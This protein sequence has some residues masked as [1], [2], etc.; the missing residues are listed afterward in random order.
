[1]S[2][3]LM[4]IDEAVRAQQMHALWSR[5]GQWLIGFAVVSVIATIIG[6]IW[7]RHVNAALEDQTGRLLT[8]LQNEAESPDTAKKLGDLAKKTDLPL[9]GVAT[10]YQAQKLEQAKDLKGAQ[11]LYGTMIEQRRLPEIIRNLSR[12]HFARIGLVIGDKPEAL[13]PVLDPVAGNITGKKQTPFHYSALELKGILLVAQGKQDEANTIFTELSSNSDVPG[14]MRA[15]AKG[16]VH[17]G[18]KNGR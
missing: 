4:E 11:Q 14:T 17:Y 10:L 5:Y 8:V 3:S 6:V 7:H 1:M 9:Q 13:L 2:E 15:R 16:M 18:D 12:V